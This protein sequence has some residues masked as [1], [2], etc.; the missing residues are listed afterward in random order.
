MSQRKSKIMRRGRRKAFGRACKAQNVSKGGR[1]TGK[2]KKDNRMKFSK[3]KTAG[4]F[5]GAGALALIAVAAMAEGN[6]RG[7]K[8]QGHERP[9]FEMLD[10]DG[11]GSVTV[12][13][14]KDRAAAEF[15][16]K[17]GNG[18]GS[19]DADELVAAMAENAKKRFE[20]MIEW[21][22]TDGDGALSQAELGMGNGA[23]MFERLDADEDGAISAE[24][25]EKAAQMRGG[26]G[27]KGK[28]KNGRHGG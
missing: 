15:A 28:G 13:E 7:F 10:A 27:G 3:Q 19:L 5:V 9:T 18:D 16:A 20:K 11:D 23:R 22:D 21:R 2:L 26:H 14:I 6:G 24:E 25:F 12:G 17:D 1:H 4:I 8:G